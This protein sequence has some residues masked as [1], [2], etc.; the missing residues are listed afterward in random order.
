MSSWDCP[1]CGFHSCRCRRED[2]ERYHDRHRFSMGF[3]RE[4]DLEKR[5][6]DLR[7]EERREELRREEEAE[8]RRWEAAREQARQ[9]QLEYERYLEEQREAWAENHPEPEREEEP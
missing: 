9:E 6:E 5:I 4:R 1:V 7:W 8:E 3:D 2:L